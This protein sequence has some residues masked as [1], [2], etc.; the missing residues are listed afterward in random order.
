[1]LAKQNGVCAACGEF[2]LR[3]GTERMPAHHNH[4]TGEPVAVLCTQCNV[5]MGMMEDSIERVRMLLAFAERY[6]LND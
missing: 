5:A 4:V 2:R 6:H 1:M 3:K